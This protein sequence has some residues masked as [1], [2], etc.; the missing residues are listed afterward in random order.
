MLK[1]ID[2]VP[3]FN[4]LDTLEIRL[5]ELDPVVD[6]FVI[7][8]SPISYMR[9]EKPLY[10]MENRARY[11]KWHK[12]IIHHTT[13]MSAYEGVKNPKNPWNIE[14]V[15]RNAPFLDMP[16]L[17]NPEDMVIRADVDEIP[18]ADFVKNHDG[19]LVRF[20]TR[21]YRFY[22]NLFFQ[23]WKCPH[24]GLWKHYMEHLPNID[25]MARPRLKNKY[26]VVSDCGWHFSSVGNFDTLWEKF[27]NFSHAPEHKR[28]R[29]L[30]KELVKKRIERRLHP[31]KNDK[32]PG[33]MVKITDMPQYVQDNQEKFAHI[34][35][36]R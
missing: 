8:E 4:E 27:T 6:V 12:K 10:F 17:F 34:L 20:E 19:R 33:R 31:F 36:G 28:N 9:K 14:R 15:Q 24:I 11:A 26:P 22:L 7:S 16:D 13:K 5:A 3:F 23:Y 21:L 1:T 29:I 35:L 32:D 2:V 30:D 18:R 25:E